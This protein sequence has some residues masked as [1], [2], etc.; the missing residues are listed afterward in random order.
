[1]V[2]RGDAILQRPEALVDLLR[3]AGGRA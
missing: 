3:G 1:V 2:W